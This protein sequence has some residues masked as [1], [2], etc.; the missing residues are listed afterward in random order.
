MFSEI[1]TVEKVV[2]TAEKVVQTQLEDIKNCGISIYCAGYDKG[3][4]QRQRDIVEHGDKVYHED[5]LNSEENILCTTQEAYQKGLEDMWNAF[6]VAYEL[7]DD[8]MEA[9]FD[10][11][12]FSSIFRKYTPTEFVKVIEDWKQQQKEMDEDEIK[13][14]DEVTDYQGNIFYAVDIC[15]GDIR[16]WSKDGIS[17][18]LDHE[19]LKKTGKHIDGISDVLQQMQEGE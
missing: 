10:D 13:V 11:I 1:G 7:P 18:L 2:Q 15:D 17:V 8:Q 4:Q 3:Y 14:G 16:C 5:G 9:V 19:C 12:W 6:H